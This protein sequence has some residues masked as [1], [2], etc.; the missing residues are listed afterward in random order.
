[1]VVNGAEPVSP[2]TIARF[3]ERFAPFGLRPE[4][5]APV[6]GLAECSVG[7]AF[8][9]VGRT[10]VVDRVERTALGRDGIARPAAP[11]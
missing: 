8:P 10:P 6:Y 4:A 1:M 5:M 2:A 7:L 3:A 11:A 9:P